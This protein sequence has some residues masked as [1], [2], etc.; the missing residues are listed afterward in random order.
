[1]KRLFLIFAVLPL[2]VCAP[3]GAQNRSRNAASRIPK[4]RFMPQWTPQAQFAGYYAALE[5]GFYAEEGIDV[6]IDHIN[7]TSRKNSLGHLRSGDVDIAMGQMLQAIVANDGD[8]SLVNVL[9]TS[10]N[11]GLCCV[12]N[13]PLPDLKAL[14]GKKVGVWKTG[15]GEIAR[16]AADEAAIHVEWVPFLSGINLLIAGATD[17]MLAYSYSELL[18]YYFAT[19]EL[20]ES[21]ILHFSAIGYNYP[22][23]GVYVTEKYLRTHRSEVE[24]FCRASRR[25]WEWVAA[26]K[27]EAL[28]IVKQYTDRF[29]VV[30]S[31]ITQRYM[32][33][34]ILSLQLDKASARSFA[35]VN[36]VL[37]VEMLTKLRTAGFIQEDVD[38]NR[39]FAK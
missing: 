19:G 39:F 28:Q 6:E 8:F 2:L 17:A 11:S 22:E 15:F 30:T 29:H 34:E 14:E 35:P 32:L 18:Q 21:K 24:K 13:F 3:A 26:N 16:V 37:F 31:D 23:D 33:D 5:K 36:E 1:M 9:Q 10:Q 38:Y 7:A 25:G 20:D 12:A 4:V 27:E